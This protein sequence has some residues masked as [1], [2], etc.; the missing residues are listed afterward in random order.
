MRAPRHC[1][2]TPAVPQSSLPV[3]ICASDRLHKDK[4]PR[5]YPIRQVVAHIMLVAV[6]DKTDGR[7]DALTLLVEKGRRVEDVE[8]AVQPDYPNVRR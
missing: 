3:L 2:P 7:T 5:V 4:P 8:V 6:G 1:A